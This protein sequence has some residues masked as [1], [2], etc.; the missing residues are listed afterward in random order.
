MQALNDYFERHE[1]QAFI[2]KAFLTIILIIFVREYLS[3]LL[4]MLFIFAPVIFLIYIRLRAA[5]DGV[6]SYELL[7]QHITFIPV[8]RTEGDRK[9]DVI[10][11]VTYSLILINVI[12]FYLYEKAPWGSMTFIEDNLLFLPVKPN[13]WNVVVSAFSAMFLHASDGHLWGNMVFLWMLGTSVERRIGDKLFALLYIITGLFGGMAFVL[14]WFMASGE[15]GH[16]LGASGAIAGIMG[17]FAVRCYFKSMIFPVPILG[18]FSLILPISL[19][20][21]LN[22]LVIIGLFFLADLSGGIG[23]LTGTGSSMIGHW[24]HLGG[25]ISG[26][27]L[28]SFLKLGR[29]AV[30]E[31]HL[32]IGVKA[33]GARVGYGGGEQSLRM[34]LQRNPENAEAMLMLARIRSKYTTSNEGRE[35]YA[36]AISRMIASQPQEAA[37]AY[38]EYCASYR[39]ALEPSVMMALAGIFQRR[40]DLDSATRCLEAV[41]GTPGVTPDLRCRALAQ[42]AAMLDKMGLEEVACGYYQTLIDEFPH[43]DI[44][45]RAYARLGKEVPPHTAAERPPNPAL[46]TAPPSVAS[47]TETVAAVVEHAPVMPCPACQ[48]IMQK[49]RASNGPHA[50]KFFW[51]CPSFPQ[52]KGIIPAGEG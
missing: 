17:I 4:V 37:Q 18:I 20:V 16:S 32:E 1:E 19:K 39:Q 49:R 30:E 42:C 25:M 13:A 51:V 5:T 38:Q 43:S 41:I 31:R 22:S 34:V 10:P 36:G 9:K 6:S 52:C 27:V 14:S 29:G 3:G 12:I 28:A 48:S 24:C 8:M 15:L 21:R 33:A 7:K 44:S 45:H 50:G 26:I 23:Q 2:A 11:W 46:Q 40:V 35:L 47:E